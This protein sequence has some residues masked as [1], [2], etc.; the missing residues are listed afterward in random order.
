MT[1]Q[2]NKPATGELQKSTSLNPTAPTPTSPN[3][4]AAHSSL[5]GPGFL[6][7]LSTSFLGAAND[8]IVKTVITNMVATGLWVGAITSSQAGEQA[9][10]AVCLTLP[11]ILLSG[12]AG[13]MA[14]R[15]SKREIMLWVKIAEIPLAIVAFIGFVTFNVW[16]TLLALVMLGI[17]SSF[18]GPAKFGSIPELVE[19]Q[20]L[21]PANGAINMCSNLGVIFGITL[22]GPIS[23][24]YVRELDG[25]MTPGVGWAPGVAILIVALFGLA[26]V[27]MMPKLKPSFTDL[28]F[29]WNPFAT[30]VQSFK[31]MGTGPL[32]V[33]V[34][35]WSGFYMIASIEILIIPIYKDYFDISYSA[36]TIL[37]LVLAIAIGVGSLLAGIL[38]GKTIRPMFIPCG[39]LGMTAGFA[40]MGAFEP[41]FV[42][43]CILLGLSGIAAGFYIVPLQALIQYLSPDDERG[44]FLGTANAMSFVFVTVGAAIFFV[45]TALWKMEEYRVNLICA[46]FALIGMVIGVLQMRRVLQ[47]R[48]SVVRP[49]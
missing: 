19:D 18:F 33:A 39:G 22:S 46:A 26:S 12:Y 34:C 4:D 35:A 49:K 7:L 2:A 16:V 48:D 1:S 13:Q 10:P 41:T 30:Y 37:M 43:T 28:K 3:K 6:A 44:R 8:N 21:S 23:D 36:Q 25:E 42:S 17:Q 27:I 20:Q 11:F 31:D 29:K 47:G 38:S 5:L 32:F 24:L 14:D 9:I 45:A 15:F 40:A